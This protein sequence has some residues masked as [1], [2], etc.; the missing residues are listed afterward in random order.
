LALRVGVF[1]TT[2]HD[3]AFLSAANRGRHELV[4]QEPHLGADTAPLAAGRPC[5]NAIRL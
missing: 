1:S 4:L 3:R 5:A 2:P